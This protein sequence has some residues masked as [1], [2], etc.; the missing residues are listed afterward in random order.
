M[1]TRTVTALAAH[2][3]QHAMSR[4]TRF[5]ESHHA[6]PA[7]AATVVADPTATRVAAEVTTGVSV[8]PH[9]TATKIR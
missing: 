6:R 3:H 8:S 1:T 5:A 2:S 4:A 7:T 9:R